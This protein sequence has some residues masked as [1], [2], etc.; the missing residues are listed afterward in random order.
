MSVATLDSRVITAICIKYANNTRT[1]LLMVLYMRAYVDVR[2]IYIDERVSVYR[3]KIRT[4]LRGRNTC[5][6]VHSCG[7]ANA[8]NLECICVLLIPVNL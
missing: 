5:S 2:Q 6:D 1:D 3:R 4:V 7:R 8:V